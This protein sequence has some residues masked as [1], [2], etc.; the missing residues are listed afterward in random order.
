MPQHDRPLA[1]EPAE[2]M[3]SRAE[4]DRQ[5]CGVHKLITVIHQQFTTFQSSSIRW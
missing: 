2:E 5:R 4:G 1:G 3:V